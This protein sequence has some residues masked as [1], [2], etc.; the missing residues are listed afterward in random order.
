MNDEKSSWHNC[1]QP[2]A[3]L[4][5]IFVTLITSRCKFCCSNVSSNAIDFTIVVAFNIQG[6]IRI[7]LCWKFLRWLQKGMWLC[8]VKTLNLINEATSF[9]KSWDRD[10]VIN[11]SET[12]SISA[13]LLPIHSFKE[14][15]KI[16]NPLLRFL[17]I[18]IDRSTK[19]SRKLSHKCAE[20]KRRMTHSY[21]ISM[22][23]ILVSV[24]SLPMEVAYIVLLLCRIVV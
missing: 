14:S 4:N 23:S 17:E 3:L 2:M 7:F 5:S 6:K 10:V 15:S 16:S 21:L 1:M 19:N 13:L 20:H 18:A 11:P 12:T 24:C 22:Q 8:R 9:E